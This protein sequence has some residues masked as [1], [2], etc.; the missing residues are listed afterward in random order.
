MWRLTYICLKPLTFVN[1]NISI[2]IIPVC[3]VSG[4]FIIRCIQILILKCKP[5]ERLDVVSYGNDSISSSCRKLA[6]TPQH[7]PKITHFR[8]TSHLTVW[9][10]KRMHGYVS[11][12]W[13]LLV[14]Q[15]RFQLC[16]GCFL[17]WCTQRRRCQ[18]GDSAAPSRRHLHFSPR[19]RCTDRSSVAVYG[20]QL[21]RHN[22]TG[23]SLRCLQ[24]SQQC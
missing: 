9:A 22:A 12:G 20:T 17:L 23:T 8:S 24:S 14:W 15:R 21:P 1:N 19:H 6:A 13:P 3:F 16:E 10:K 2:R 5:L 18:V 4:R 7:P 11:S